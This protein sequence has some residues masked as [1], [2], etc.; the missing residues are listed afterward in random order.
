MPWGRVFELPYQIHKATG[1]KIRVTGLP[2]GKYG[3]PALK[4]VNGL[5]GSHRYND[6]QWVGF[7]KDFEAIIDLGSE[8]WLNK[9]GANVLNYA[10]QRMWPPVSL[11]FYVS[12]NGTDYTKVAVLQSFPVNGINQ[13]RK[14]IEP[15]KARYVKISGRHPGII[16]EGKYGAGSTAL[17]MI[18]EF[19]LE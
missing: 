2:S 8:Q 19:I 18:D 16:P 17:V 6:N 14:P 15:V 11:D 5:P 3:G 4:L 13:A 7:T 12:G 1:A 9:V 10:W